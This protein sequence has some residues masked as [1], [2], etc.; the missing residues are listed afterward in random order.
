[1]AIGKL[2]KYWALLAIV[3]YLLSATKPTIIGFQL[4][5]ENAIGNILKFNKLINTSMSS[6][7]MDQT[8]KVKRKIEQKKV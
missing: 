8:S 7:S 2:N 5:K 4:K 6:V 1:M 3:Y